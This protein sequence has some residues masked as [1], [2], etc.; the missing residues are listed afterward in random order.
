MQARTGGVG[1]VF[2]ASGVGSTTLQSGR[3]AQIVNVGVAPREEPFD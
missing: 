2:V 1:L 3:A